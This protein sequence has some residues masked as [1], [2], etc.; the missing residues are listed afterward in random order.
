MIKF[1]FGLFSKLTFICV[2]MTGSPLGDKISIS[3]KGEDLMY[4]IT[5]SNNE[6]NTF[7]L[8]SDKITISKFKVYAPKVDVFAPN[9]DSLMLVDPTASTYQNHPKVTVFV[10]FKYKMSGTKEYTLPL[11]T[12]VSTRS[13]SSTK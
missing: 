8:N 13:Y 12:S 6:P 10:E 1:A 11:Q 3:F 5:N 2:E 4:A 9:S 7:A